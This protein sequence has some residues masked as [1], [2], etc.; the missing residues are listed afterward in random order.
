M[1][2]IPAY[3]HIGLPVAALTFLVR[4]ARYFY[5]FPMLEFMVNGIDNPLRRKMPPPNQTALALG[6]A[7][8]LTVLEVEPGNGTYTLAVAHRVGGRPVA[9]SH[10]FGSETNP[11]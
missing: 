3:L 11:T 8:G 5:K 9:I 7:P 6:I 1:L 4:T 10:V 2:K